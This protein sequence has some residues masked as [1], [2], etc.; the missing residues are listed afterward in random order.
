MLCSALC[1]PV[2]ILSFPGLSVV[3]LSLEGDKPASAVPPLASLPPFCFPCPADESN[4]GSLQG[5]AMPGRVRPIDPI[6][7][8]GQDEGDPEGDKGDPEGQPFWN[9]FFVQ[10]CGF[11]PAPFSLGPTTP[12]SSSCQPLGRLSRKHMIIKAAIQTWT[13]PMSWGTGRRGGEEGDSLGLGETA[14]PQG[15]A[16]M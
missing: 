2:L 6:S 16:L 9:A 12:S 10:L 14:A 7:N 3:S 11:K 4:T 1:D 15:Y 8:H 13:C 5:W